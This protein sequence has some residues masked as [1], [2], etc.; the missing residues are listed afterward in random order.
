MTKSFAELT[1]KLLQYSEK[2]YRLLYPIYTVAAVSTLKPLD[3][4]Y[5]YAGAV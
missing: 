2:L 3:Q 4:H 1:T 5:K